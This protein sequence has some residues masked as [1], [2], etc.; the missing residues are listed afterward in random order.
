MTTDRTIAELDLSD[1]EL[2]EVLKNHGL[3]RRVLMKALGA[4]TGVAALGG[5]ATAGG[6]GSG[7]AANA[8]GN[9]DDFYGAS[10]SSDET[11]PNIYDHT[12]ELHTHGGEH[13]G[14]DE[15][16][17]HE[18]F[19][20]PDDA[21][22]SDPTTPGFQPDSDD[23][24]DYPEFHFEPVGLH[25]KPGDVVRFKSLT[26][27]HTVTAY[28]PHFNETPFLNFQER[29][30]D[31]PFTSALLADGDSWLYRFTEKGV[32]DIQCLPHARLGM[33]MR[34]LVF[35]P[36]ED[37][38]DDV[39]EPPFGSE[40]RILPNAAAVL[41]ELAPDR[42][43][44]Q[45][46]V[47]WESLSLSGPGSVPR[48]SVDSL[49]LTPDSGSGTVVADWEVSDPGPGALNTVQLTLREKDG[50]EVADATTD[51]ACAMISGGSYSGSTDLDA[52]SVGTTDYRV[53][54]TVTNTGGLSVTDTAS[55]GGS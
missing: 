34:V 19:P 1:A 7:P 30:P 25:V 43:K 37:D 51:V 40:G 24:D 9:I 45:G 22:D 41:G 38:I 36:E 23:A 44:N 18:G 26:P 27:L 4:G 32:Y 11:V 55:T 5:T 33:V 12:V 21:V 35:D 8:K 47:A 2:L 13:H 3:S 48:P 10:Y 6:G 29:V 14:E 16:G 53:E 50:E 46:E 31:G 52:G 54:L 42:I 20:V 28:H 39:A 15:D 17:A 49:S